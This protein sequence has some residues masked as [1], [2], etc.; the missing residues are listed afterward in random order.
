MIFKY[1]QFILSKNDEFLF[2][3]QGVPWQICAL[4]IIKFGIESNIS[5]LKKIIQE[6]MTIFHPSVEITWSDT[7]VEISQSELK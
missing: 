5:K 7:S 4:E 3:L 1:Y 6:K 2:R